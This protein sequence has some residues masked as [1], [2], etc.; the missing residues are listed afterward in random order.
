M[1]AYRVTLPLFA[2]KR[3]RW[4][5]EALAW[6]RDQRQA[7]AQIV[8]DHNRHGKGTIVGSKAVQA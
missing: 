5:I 2:R 7:I 8:R 4:S 6:A 1:N 3:G